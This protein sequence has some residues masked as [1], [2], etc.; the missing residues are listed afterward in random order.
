M[1]KT[2]QRKLGI[3]VRIKKHKLPVKKT[4]QTK[5]D[6]YKKKGEN[7]PHKRRGSKARYKHFTQRN[8]KDFDKDTYK[9]VPLNH[10]KYKGKKFKGYNKSGTNAKAVIGT[11][12]KG[13]KGVIQTIL[14]PKK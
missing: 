8:K 1:P 2:K 12:K 4:K 5:I 10:T 14:I 11:T 7:M 6:D 9:T 3:S 13:K